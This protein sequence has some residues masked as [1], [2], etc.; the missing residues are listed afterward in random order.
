MLQVVFEGNQETTLI[1]FKV[2]KNINM[3]KDI[4]MFSIKY[5]RLKKEGT[6]ILKF[7]CMNPEGVQKV[8]QKVH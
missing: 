2:L 8:A 6:N 5:N 4:K 3:I 7:I 1:R